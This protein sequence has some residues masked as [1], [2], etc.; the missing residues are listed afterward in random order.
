M[1]YMATLVKRKKRTRNFSM[2]LSTEE[3]L[4]LEMIAVERG[5]PATAVV[6]QLVREAARL[7]NRDAPQT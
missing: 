4:A 2:R 7:L 6:R 5:L 3:R 1:R